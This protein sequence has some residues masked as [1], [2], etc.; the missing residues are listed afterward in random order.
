MSA[1]GHK[2]SLGEPLCYVRQELNS[3]RARMIANYDI[4]LGR[5]DD[6]PGI[7]ALQETNLAE[8]GG[9]LAVRQTA[10]CKLLQTH[11]AGRPAMTF[12]RADNVASLRAH[13]KMGMVELGTFINEGVPHIALSY[14]G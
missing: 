5:V 1:L 14:S 10:D 11:M 6:I 9:G 7:L 12:V 3:V 4:S 13:R 8:R 2:R